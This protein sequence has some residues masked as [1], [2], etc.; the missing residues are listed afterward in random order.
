MLKLETISTILDDFGGAP[1][2]VQAGHCLNARHKDAGCRLCVDACPTD[3]IG[4]QLGRPHLESDRCVS[5]GLCLHWCPTDVFAQRSASEDSLAQTVSL[6]SDDALS[7]VCSQ[8]GDPATTWAPVTAVVQ[9]KRCLASLSVPQLMEL[10]DTGRR[11]IWLDDSACAEC[12]IGR[13]QPAIA[14]TAATTNRL[15]QAFG[16]PPAIRTHVSHSDELHDDPTPRTVID[17]DQPELSR[18]SFFSALGQLTRRTA[19]TVITET[20]A[21]PVSDAPVPVDQ[22]LPHRIPP[23]RGHLFGQLKGLGTPADEPFGTAGIPFAD[24]NVDAD[25]CSGCRLCARFCPTGALSFVA[26]AERFVLYFRP[27]ICIDCGICAVACP[28][29]A[30]SFGQRLV[31]EALIG[32]EPRP[33]VAGKLAPCAGCGEPTAALSDDADEERCYVCRRA[34]DPMGLILNN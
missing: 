5:C 29:N 32:V 16:H 25:A 7:L 1:V 22:R 17:A 34:G 14:Q 3:A 28:E 4:L 13:A 21:T 26:D 11:T 2:S 20:L 23:S 15:L 30:V 27:A 9:H 33:L 8:H 19:A 10:T 31:A 12:P 6:L 24:V 18:R